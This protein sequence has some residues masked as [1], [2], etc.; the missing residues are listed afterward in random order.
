MENMLFRVLEEPILQIIKTDKSQLVFDYPEDHPIRESIIRRIQ[1]SERF[2]KGLR[3][4]D[5]SGSLR[6]VICAVRDMIDAV[7]DMI[8][9]S[10]ECA[11]L[12]HAYAQKHFWE[13]RAVMMTIIA[14]LEQIEITLEHLKID[15]VV[16]DPKYLN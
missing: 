11:T 12:G 1:A 15:V 9:A 2:I 7:R 16:S 14:K 6:D 3:F 8:E 10:E 4:A 5:A 13:A